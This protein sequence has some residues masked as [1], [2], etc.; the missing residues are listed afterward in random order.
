MKRGLQDFATRDLTVIGYRDSLADAYSLMVQKGV[1]HLPVVDE[2]RAIIGIISDRDFMRAM[3]VESAEGFKAPI[4]VPQFE[5]AATVRDFMS[6]PVESIETTDSIGL[7]ARMMLERKISALLVTEDARVV[8]ILT[9]EDLLR[10]LI[11]EDQPERPVLE[12]ELGTDLRAAL[13]NSPVG[14]IAQTLANAGV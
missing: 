5:G 11:D 3:K 12:N 13:Y 14:Q 7:A 4:A 1:R 6:W 10:C 9:T 2:N 8:G